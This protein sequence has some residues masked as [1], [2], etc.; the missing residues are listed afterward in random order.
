[1]IWSNPE[2]VMTLNISN[3]YPLHLACEYGASL[4]IIKALSSKSDLVLAPCDEGKTPISLLWIELSRMRE[5]SLYPLEMGSSDLFISLCLLL[6]VVCGQSSSREF[7]ADPTNLIFAALKIGDECPL[8]FIKFIL[9]QFPSLV[10]AKDEHGMLLLHHCC[11]KSMKVMTVCQNKCELNWSDRI[12]IIS[13][14]NPDAA[15]VRDNFGRLPIHYLLAS[16]NY[17]AQSRMDCVKVLAN[18]APS[19]IT[20]VDTVT[21]LYPFMLVMANDCSCLESCKWLLLR[22]PMVLSSSISCDTPMPH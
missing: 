15:L 4:E 19:S 20:A 12:K 18:V 9:R 11:E 21:G 14:F 16:S 10:K 5:D 22:N 3:Q 13:E 7:Y 17:D 8:S 2:V 1:M 6:A